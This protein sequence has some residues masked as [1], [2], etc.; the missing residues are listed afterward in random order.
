MECLNYKLQPR[1]CKLATRLQDKKPNDFIG[2]CNLATY[3]YK[4]KDPIYGVLYDEVYMQY[5]Y[6]A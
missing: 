1:G 2:E 4:S 5:M 6:R 3:I